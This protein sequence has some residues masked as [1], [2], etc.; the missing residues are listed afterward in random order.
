MSPAALDRW[1]N[2]DARGPADDQ[3][4]DP[5]AIR[6]KERANHRMLVILLARELYRRDHGVDAPSAE[7]LVGP[8]LKELPDGS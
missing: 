1:L 4:L 8:Y 6:V 3:R 5:R 7:A 2:Y